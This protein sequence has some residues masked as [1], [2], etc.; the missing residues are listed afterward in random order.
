MNRLEQ[1]KCQAI[2]SIKDEQLLKLNRTVAGHLRLKLNE[3]ILNRRKHICSKIRSTTKP[4]S[5]QF[6]SLARRLLKKANNLSA[7]KNIQ[8]NLATEW[9]EIINI[10]LDELTLIFSGK[11]SPI[12]SNRNGQIIKEVVKKQSDSWKPWIPIV[13]NPFAHKAEVC[14]E[15]KE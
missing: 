14:K 6:W 4:S 7:I 10:V 13:T 1:E 5:K 2:L 11:R 3:Q 15:V 12:F 8:G 9:D